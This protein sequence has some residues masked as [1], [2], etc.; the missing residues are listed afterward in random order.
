MHAAIITFT[1]TF[2]IRLTVC[3]F[4]TFLITFV[5]LKRKFEKIHK[6]THQ[7]TQLMPVYETVN[8]LA[9]T[10]SDVKLQA[11]PAYGTSGGVVMDDNPAYQSYNWSIYTL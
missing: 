9:I 8:T 3:V 11:N 10:K 7:P 6:T 1:T 5:I 4:V 2:I